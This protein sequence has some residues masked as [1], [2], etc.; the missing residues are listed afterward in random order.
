MQISI[1]KELAR[2]HRL[3]YPAEKPPAHHFLFTS[4]P[5]PLGLRIRARTRG[6]RIGYITA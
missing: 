1:T 5:N 3:C 6:T 2:P 4:D